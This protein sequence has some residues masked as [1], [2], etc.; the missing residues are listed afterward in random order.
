MSINKSNYS[1][2]LLF[3]LLAGGAAGALVTVLTALKNG[4]NFGEDSKQK[5][6]DYLDETYKYFQ[7]TEIMAG[8]RLNELSS[9]K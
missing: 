3:G 4:K 2:G 6:G 8:E 1:N 9:A 7:A 5:S